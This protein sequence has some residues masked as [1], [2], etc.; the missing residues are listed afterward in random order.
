MLAKSKNV[1]WQA[2]V[3]SFASR[4]DSLN[5]LSRGTKYWIENLIVN[6]IQHLF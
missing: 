4:T 2:E 1:S 3:E 6:L 5:K